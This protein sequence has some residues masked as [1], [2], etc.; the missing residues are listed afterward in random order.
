MP[1]E[2]DPI[3]VFCMQQLITR[4]IPQDTFLRWL[5]HYL[6]GDEY[7]SIEHEGYSLLL[8]LYGATCVNEWHHAIM[9]V[10]LKTADEMNRT[11]FTKS[12][13]NG[14]WFWGLS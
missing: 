6:D 13:D 1:V 2:S 14:N 5:E 3:K 10:P 4:S 11:V 12:V 9:D 7:A 8:D